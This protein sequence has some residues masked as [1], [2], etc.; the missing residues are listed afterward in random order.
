MEEKESQDAPVLEDKEAGH[1][2]L[3]MGDAGGSELDTTT[4]FKVINRQ[5][6]KTTGVPRRRAQ[7]S[8]STTK[9]DPIDK[10]KQLKSIEGV[11]L[12]VSLV[13]QTHPGPDILLTKGILPSSLCPPT[14]EFPIRCQVV[15]THFTESVR[16]IAALLETTGGLEKATLEKDISALTQSKFLNNRE[17][18]DIVLFTLM[19]RAGLRA[20]W[21]GLCVRHENFF[22]LDGSGASLTAFFWDKEPV[23]LHWTR[24]MRIPE[25]REAHSLVVSLHKCPVEGVMSPK[26][27]A[28]TPFPGS[29]LTQPVVRVSRFRHAFYLRGILLPAQIWNVASLLASRHVAADIIPTYLTP[30]CQMQRS[31]LL[32]EEKREVYTALCVRDGEIFSL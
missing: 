29:V 23:A 17:D 32:G 24:G 13:V 6:T 5:R 11:A 26:L 14:Y 18:E 30:S 12:A 19:F 31:G 3:N 7:D 27:L 22:I 25:R 28:L 2:H 4:L 21:E 8:A 20:L 16:R 9:R 15:N 10:P 1:G